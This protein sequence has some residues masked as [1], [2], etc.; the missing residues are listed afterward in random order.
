MTP[1]FAQVLL[2]IIGFLMFWLC[3]FLLP[4]EKDYR[5]KYE[6]GELSPEKKRKMEKD[7]KFVKRLVY[8]ALAAMCPL[9]F[10]LVFTAVFG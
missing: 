9:V 3:M 4:E 2:F 7:T 5:E 10:N 8:L 1:L 6:H